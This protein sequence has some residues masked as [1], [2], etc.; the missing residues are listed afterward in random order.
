MDAKISN[1]KGV[2]DLAWS[3]LIDLLT[4]SCRPLFEDI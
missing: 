3:H 4:L 2:M 1:A